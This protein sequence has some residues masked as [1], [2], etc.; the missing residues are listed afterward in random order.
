MMSER[1]PRSM[2]PAAGLHRVAERVDRGI[3]EVDTAGQ[4]TAEAG[5]LMGDVGGRGAGIDAGDEQAFAVAGGEELE[6]VGDAR[7]A[8]GQHDDAVG[9]A[10]ERDLLARQQ[11]NKN[12]EAEHKRDAAKDGKSH[13]KRPDPPRPDGAPKA[14]HRRARPSRQVSSR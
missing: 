1:K 4:D 12:D 8:A 14:E 11:P 6:R 13:R 7:G 2:R 3:V 10:V 9:I 5:G